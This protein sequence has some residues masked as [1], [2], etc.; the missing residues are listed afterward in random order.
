[1]KLR[2]FPR[3]RL[4]AVL[5]LAL[6]VSALFVTRVPPR[7]PGWSLVSW[8]MEWFPSGFPEPLPAADEAERIRTAGR[9]LRAGR[10]PDVFVAQEI[11]DAAT[12][13]NLALRVGDPAFVPIVCSDFWYNPTNRCLQQIAIF[14]R[15][16]AVAAG[17]EP[18]TSRDFIF[19]PRGY[20][21]AIL[22][23][24]AGLV[25]VF[26]VHLK[27][28]YVAEGQDA[29]RQAVLNRLKRELSAEQLLAHVDRLLTDGIGGTNLTGI[30]VAGDFN[31]AAEDER[32]AEETTM[33]KFLDRGFRDAFEGI[34]ESERTTLPA[35]GIYPDATFDHIY[36]IGLDA[37]LD[38]RV[39]P[40]CP[41]SDH[42]PIRA[43]FRKTLSAPQSTREP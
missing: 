40:K 1:M 9:A 10:V 15:F 21:W 37:P 38:R 29:E 23:T 7:E 22:D 32:F 2:L 25:G 8:N 28:N 41:V 14:S 6:S 39:C 4:L 34:P 5:A 19:P 43:Q 18:W 12:C 20:A 30:V 31:T 17:F 24:G 16:P 11:R 26:G 35:D 13:T 42:L 3:P 27:S 36:A 33:R